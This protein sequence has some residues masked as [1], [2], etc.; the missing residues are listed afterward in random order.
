MPTI[1]KLL[2][3]SGFASALLFNSITSVYA[4]IQSTTETL[5]AG[6]SVLKL[7]LED[8]QYL[9]TIRRTRLIITFTDISDDSITLIDEISESSEQSLDELENLTEEKPDIIY[10]DFS[11]DT[12][13]S[14]TLN[15]LR[16]RTAKEFIFDGENFEKNL[17]LSQLKV[18]PVIFHLAEELE[19]KETNENRKRWLKKLADHYEKHYLKINDRILI[20]SK[21]N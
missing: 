17:L 4:N 13:A 10:L 11:N 14:A 3:L 16:M 7:L 12:I 2:L 18:L 15:S 1:K 20:V 6:Y 8:E 9:T 5:S 21:D 19:K